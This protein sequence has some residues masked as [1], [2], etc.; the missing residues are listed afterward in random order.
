MNLNNINNTINT[1]VTVPTDSTSVS[2]N[3][4]R[5]GQNIQE[6]LS[7]SSNGDIIKGV[8]IAKEDGDIQISLGNDTLINAKINSSADLQIGST[9][10]FS[11]RSTDNNVLL[12]S[13]LYT[14]TDPTSTIAKALNNA[15]LI[16]DDRGS[17][18]ISSM[19]HGG[20]NIGKDEVLFMSKSLSEVSTAD[21]PD[22][23]NLIRLGIE[24]TPNNIEQF[25][26]YLNYEHQIIGAVDEIINLIPDTVNQLVSENNTQG[27]IELTRDLLDVFT[28]KGAMESPD[29]NSLLTDK[30]N[31]PVNQILPESELQELTSLL[32]LNGFDESFGEEI[33]K[34]NVSL[35]EVLLVLDDFVNEQTNEG[36]N[37][38]TLNDA[39]LNETI[40]NSTTKAQASTTEFDANEFLKSLGKQVG[41]T[42]LEKNDSIQSNNTNSLQSNNNESD[43]NLENNKT[44]NL[45]KLILS[46]SLNSL[47]KASVNTSWKLDAYQIGEDKQVSNLYHR[48]TEQATRMLDALSLQSKSDTPLASATTQLTNN[49]NFMNEL[50]SLMN[51]VQLPMRLSGSDAH[52]ELYVY[53]NKKNLASNDGNVSALLHLDMDHLG[54]TDVYVSMSSNNHVSTHF[55]LQDDE[56]LDLIALHIDELNSKIEKRGYTVT[57][58]FKLKDGETNVMKEILDDSKLSVPISMSNFDAKA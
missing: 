36:I 44:E 35:N 31:I 51:Y 54:P 26:A 48:M 24:P 27:A 10:T 19:M 15:G 32:T 42:F 29:N 50:N 56:A 57:S 37:E 58:E 25:N 11:V 45:T 8:V 33:I 49:M 22:A 39:T 2:N 20:M 14:N 13:P 41:Q 5:N 17:A 4:L 55:Y 52:G 23:V 53:T 12:L 7:K 6:I 16:N 30:M 21:I 28:F 1:R 46:K 38:S 3:E 40:Q 43:L 18:M 47:M 34:G 9:V